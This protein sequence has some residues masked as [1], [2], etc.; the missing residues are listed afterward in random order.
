[1]TNHPFFC[2][3]N[4]CG[5]KLVSLRNVRCIVCVRASNTICLL[6]G[7]GGEKLEAHTRR[8]EE[9]EEEG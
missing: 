7:S 6:S 1:M 9:E 4:S 5:E 2:N 8:E 3:P